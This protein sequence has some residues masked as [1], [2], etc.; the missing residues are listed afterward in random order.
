VIRFVL[1]AAFA[2][3]GIFIAAHVVHGIVI[4]S[5]WS[6]AWMALLLGVINAFIRPIVVFFTLPFTILTLGLF[7]LVVNGAMLGLAAMFFRGVEVHGFWAAVLG[8][9]IVSITSWVGSAFLGGDDRARER[10]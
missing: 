10:S 7:L 5:Y 2:A 4:H 9:L 8:A 1:R 3:A 6:L